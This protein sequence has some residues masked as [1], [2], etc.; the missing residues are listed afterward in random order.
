MAQREESFETLV[1]MVRTFCRSEVLTN[2]LDRTTPLR[3]DAMN[4]VRESMPLQEGV[5]MALPVDSA[6][7]APVLSEHKVA[8][9]LTAALNDALATLARQPS[10]QLEMGQ[11][12]VL[13][14]YHPALQP[15]LAERQI[16]MAKAV[17][18][19]EKIGD[20]HMYSA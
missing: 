3:T 9:R 5:L 4:K 10:N 1:Q 18:A 17:A 12:D 20:A 11:D 7:K 13:P 19:A 15:H 6:P 14:Q 16:N 2:D 8:E